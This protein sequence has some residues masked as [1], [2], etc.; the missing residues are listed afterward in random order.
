MTLYEIDSQ[1]KAIIDGAYD[2]VDENGEVEINMEDLESL[3]IDR[4]TK[5][6]N[7]ALYI[8]NLDAEA[9]A[10]KAEEEAL[11]KRRKR[12]ENKADGLRFLMIGSIEANGDKEFSTARCSAKVKYTDRTEIDDIDA[13]PEEYIKIKTEKQADKTAIKKAIKAGETVNGARIVINKT[14][15]IE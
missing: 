5:L 12:L 14:V 15:R 1:I 2:S 11:A 3:L 7:I 10:I 9:A 8:K 13:I 6:E 4:R